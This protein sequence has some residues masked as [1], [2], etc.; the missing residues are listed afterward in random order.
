ML[1]VL[2]KSSICTRIQVSTVSMHIF[3]PFLDGKKHHLPEV[4]KVPYTSCNGYF[5]GS[6]DHGLCMNG[7]STDWAGAKIDKI[8]GDHGPAITFS[9]YFTPFP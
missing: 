9:P 3:A 5:T 1:F 6:V 7:Y 2:V 8:L 4:F